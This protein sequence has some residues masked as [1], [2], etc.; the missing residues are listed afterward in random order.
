MPFGLCNATEAFQKTKDYIFQNMRL[1]PGACIDDIL[2]YTKTLED[3]RQALRNVYDKLQQERFFAPRD[4]CT[5][6]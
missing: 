3:Y 1:F 4:K 2:I 5:W 6:A